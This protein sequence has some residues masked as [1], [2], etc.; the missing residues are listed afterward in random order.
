MQALRRKAFRMFQPIARLNGHV[1]RPLL[2]VTREE[3]RHWMEKGEY[4][5]R[6]DSSN[7]EDVYLRNQVRN[8]LI[9]ELLKIQPSLSDHMEERV[10]LY[11]AQ[12]NL[13]ER[14]IVPH[15]GEIIN[16][17]EGNQT[18]YLQNILHLYGQD[19]SAVL[20][21]LL[22]RLGEPA[23]VGNQVIRLMT[24]DTGKK[25]LGLKGIYYR[26]R[27]R[28]I[29]SPYQDMPQEVWILPGISEVVYGKWK[30]SIREFRPSGNFIPEKSSEIL[31]M[32]AARL[33]LPLRVRPWAPGDK[34]KPLGMEGS[35]KVSDIL[36][37]LKLPP[38]VRE[39]AF[40]ISSE[41]RII[42]VQGYRI[43]NKVRYR[44]DTRR[45]LEIRITQNV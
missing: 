22:D 23:S 3:I 26:D 42:F 33:K 31:V 29:Q 38:P 16:G 45:V 19:G 25:V 8:R 20:A 30:L 7:A 28:I 41:D 44:K 21:Y 14:A 9:P 18:I 12:Y 37:G 39:S 13:L 2:G 40:V 4:S 15:L 36:T 35:R 34:M 11:Q 1:V 17:N 6:E 32:D 10:V 43:A 24:S 5:W 27:D